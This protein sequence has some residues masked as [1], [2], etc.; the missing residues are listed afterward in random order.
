MRDKSPSPNYFAHVL[1]NGNFVPQQPPSLQN[2]I[3][4]GAGR[5]QLVEVKRLPN[6]AKKAKETPFD[7]SPGI[8]SSTFKQF[9]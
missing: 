9:S 6:L 3:S 4:R 8:K 5:G 1:G 2:W 7:N